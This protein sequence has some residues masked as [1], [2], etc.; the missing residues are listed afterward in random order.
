MTGASK[1]KILIQKE[2]DKLKTRM[3]S[4]ADEIA[5]SFFSFSFVRTIIPTANLAFIL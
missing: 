5:A 1:L 3:P 2:D 4:Y